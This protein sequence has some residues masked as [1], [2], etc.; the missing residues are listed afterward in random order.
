MKSQSNT[1]R[2]KSK[3]EKHSPPERKTTVRD[4]LSP[5]RR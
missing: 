4:L 5:M 3:Y 2:N 1:P